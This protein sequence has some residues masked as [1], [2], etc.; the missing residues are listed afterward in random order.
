MEEGRMKTPV[1]TALALL[2]LGGCA[3][4]LPQS[5][6]AY[7]SAAVPSSTAGRWQGTA[8]ENFGYHGGAASAKLTLDLNP[9]GTWTQAWTER[10]RT[11]S[12]SGRWVMQ[13]RSVVLQSTGG[14]SRRVT[15][16]RN[17]D[18]L[19]GVLDQSWLGGRT[20]PMTIELHRVEPN[21]KP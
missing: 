4:S 17:G 18:G 8:I 14:M 16:R 19:Y 6:S 10:G 13:G 21:P 11:V 7:E 20:T 1:A 3:T 5:G 2:L 12:D 9:D 15:L